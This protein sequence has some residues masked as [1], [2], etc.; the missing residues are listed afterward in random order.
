MAFGPGV[1]QEVEHVGRLGGEFAR[2]LSPPHDSGRSQVIVAQKGIQATLECHNGGDR[3][4][5]V[6]SRLDWLAAKGVK[7]GC[8]G[9]RCPTL[10]GLDRG[11]PAGAT[12]VPRGGLRGGRP[13][14]A[15]HLR[16]V[17][18]RDEQPS[19]AILDGR[20]LQSTPESGAHAG[21]DGAKK[22]NGSKVHIAVDTLGNLLALKVT[23]RTN[24]SGRRWRNWR[25]GSKR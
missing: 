25:S 8:S 4:S 24:R 17:N 23:R 1:G 18:D 15:D 13:R 22:K 20:T 16:F 21:Y 11:L 3:G 5:T 12:V 2:G 19:A 10:P 7:T 9:G 6:C 14:S